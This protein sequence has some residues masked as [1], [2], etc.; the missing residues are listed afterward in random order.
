M[1]RPKKIKASEQ[2]VP[3]SITKVERILSA[4]DTKSDISLDDMPLETLHDYIEYNKA[5]RALNKKLKIYRH[6]MKQCP[7]ELHPHE[8]VEFTRND[9][10]NNK[11]QVYLCNAI[12]DFK[13]D[14]YPG[15]KH[16]LPRMVIEHLSKLG[17]PIWEVI[18]KK[19]GSRDT[20]QTGFTPRFALRTIYEG[21]DGAIGF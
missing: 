2:Q 3:A 18:D 20:I 11:M 6:A 14:I 9:Q 1:P 10:P 16:R 12:I 17:T 15:K 8:T 19:D 21:N 7:I 4:T 5:A 13:L